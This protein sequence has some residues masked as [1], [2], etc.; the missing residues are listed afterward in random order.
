MIL[1]LRNM[2][3]A[4]VSLAFFHSASG[5]TP[6]FTSSFL[7]NTSTRSI[8]TIPTASTL[9][10]IQRCALN[11][12]RECREFRAFSHLFSTSSSTTD[13]A[14][15]GENDKIT[16]PMTLL[17]G[18]LG[19]GKT[20]TLQNLL[21]NNGGLKIGIIV[22]DVASINID[23]K[24]LANPSI[25]SGDTIELQ[26]GCACCSLAD[27]LLTSV[28]KLMEGGRKLDAIVVELSG[29]ADPVAVKNNWEQA[30]FGNHPATKLGVKLDKVVTLVDSST[31]GTDWM[32]WDKGGDREA[33]G[34]N[35]EDCEANKMVPELL[36]E[37]VEAADILIINK[38]DLAGEE[39]VAIATTLAQGLNAKAVIYKTKFGE[40]SVMQILQGDK[41]DR[42]EESKEDDCN[43]PGCAD[44]SHSH[45][46]DDHGEDCADTACTDAT[47]DHSHSNDHGEDCADTKCTDPT[48][49][50]SHDNDH[51]EPCAETACTDPTHDHS[52]SHEHTEACADPVCT[53]PTHDHSH[54][55]EHKSTSADKLGITN[56]VYKSD[57]PFNPSK[58]IS[59]LNK[60]PVP[61]K[62]KLDFGQLAEAAEEG[63]N[64]DGKD[65]KSPF[66]G[67]LRSKGF[68]WMAPTQWTGDNEDVWRHNTSMYWSHA[69][70]HFGLSAS[71]KWWGTIPKDTLKKY[72]I[73]NMKEYERIIREDFVSEEFGDRR[74]EIVFIGAFID[75]NEITKALNECLFNDV[76]MEEYRA[77]LQ[78]FEESKKARFA[79]S[80]K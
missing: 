45:S 16:I 42:G 35:P 51:E 19:S 50:H 38:I 17:A 25:S 28:E 4:S 11:H 79:K 6:R 43:E 20:S 71:G 44:T 12:Q 18:F 23:A 76:E 24:L 14:D 55:H 21:T 29:V 49:D 30:V 54:T 32:T 67:V 60:W 64:I 57:R 66:V 1:D 15:A 48:H 2:A 56:F 37:Q 77:E 72:F 10:T 13:K 31:F 36:A 9:S 5:F 47:H 63:Y 27:E 62:E 53:D 69:G 73:L 52:H 80:W 8:A 58:L 40:V 22:N 33:W 78:N 7:A 26:D 75:E 34:I 65:E 59:V 61:I 74:Q 46:H 3:L 39:Q 41:V 68:C 70:K